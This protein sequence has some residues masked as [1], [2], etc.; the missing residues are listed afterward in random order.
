MRPFFER[1]SSLG[2]DLSPFCLGLDP[3]RATLEAAG[4]NDDVE[5]LQTF[6][7]GMLKAVNGLTSMIKPQM[8]YFERKGPDGL[9][10][11]QRVGD[12]ARERGLLLPARRQ[13]R[14]HRHH[15]RR[16][17]RRLFGPDS[18]YRADA[19][20]VSPYLGFGALEPILEAAADNGAGIFVVVL[21]SNPE[22]RVIQPRASRK[23]V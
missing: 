1:F 16:L 15:L 19:V 23:R 18:P 3:S 12:M 21:S 9:K 14:R 7:E 4:L 6:C 17:C 13:A 8:A 22:G 2:D 5:G 20:T 11:L 10:V